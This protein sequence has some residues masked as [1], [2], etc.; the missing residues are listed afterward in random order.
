MYQRRTKAPQ[1]F[2][3]REM[4]MRAAAAPGTHRGR[5][6]VVS[7]LTRAVEFTALTKERGAE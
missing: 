3:G 1:K 7:G 5:S 4:P 2:S 6:A